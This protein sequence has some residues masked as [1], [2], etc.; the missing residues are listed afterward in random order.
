M[1]FY[2]TL[3]INDLPVGKY[4]PIGPLRI[5]PIFEF[6]WFELRSVNTKMKYPITHL[7]IINKKFRLKGF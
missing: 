5:A 6:G 2:G 4:E 7:V 3:S 1:K